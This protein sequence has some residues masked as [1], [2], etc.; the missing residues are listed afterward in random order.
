MFQIYQN[1][2]L[3]GEKYQDYVRNSIYDV[4]T[5]FYS[6]IMKSFPLISES[7]FFVVVVVGLFLMFKFW[8]NCVYTGS[9]NNSRDV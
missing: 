8:N 4:Q 6:V 2:N 9:C 3:K 7:F 5:C 1:F